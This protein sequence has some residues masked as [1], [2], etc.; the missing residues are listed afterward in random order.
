MNLLPGWTPAVVAGEKTP[1]LTYVGH[2]YS[3][4]NTTS[5]TVGSFSLPSP[6]S[7]RL[8]VAVIHDENSSISNVQLGG[9]SMSAVIAQTVFGPLSL[10]IYQLQSNTLTGNVNVTY[11]LSQSENSHAVG[12]YYIDY[13]SNISAHDS[14]TE[15]KDFLTNNASVQINVPSNGVVIAGA[16]Q[17]DSNLA[18][19]SWTG[20][21]ENYDYEDAGRN[22]GSSGASVSELAA[23]TNRT[24]SI[25]TSAAVG[26]LGL[27]AASWG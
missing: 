1:A 22:F 3:L 5:V 8:F 25:N 24:I 17:S 4:N 11:N 21:S 26:D 27:V 14:A 10:S 23:E 12:L 18:N 9:N 15:V 16:S 7:G 2:V 20:V 6:R 19:I 13:L